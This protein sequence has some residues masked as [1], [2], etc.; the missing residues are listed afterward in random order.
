M[1]AILG[2]RIGQ[3]QCLLHPINLLTTAEVGGRTP[4]PIGFANGCRNGYNRPHPDWN[5]RGDVL[6]EFRKYGSSSP[7]A[8]NSE[9]QAEANLP[10]K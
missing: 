8:V 4:S 10:T 1:P 9:R 6:R 7:F 3:Q 2:R 5:M